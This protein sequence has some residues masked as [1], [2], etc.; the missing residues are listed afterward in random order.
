MSP[1]NNCRHLQKESLVSYKFTYKKNSNFLEN[2]SSNAYKKLVIKMHPIILDMLEKVEYNY[3]L[4]NKATYNFLAS[5]KLKLLY[6]HFC[7]LTLP[8]SNFVAIYLSDLLLLWP[9]SSQPK[10]LQRRKKEMKELLK[11]FVSLESKIDDL[12]VKTIV[13]DSEIIGV[14]VRKRKLSLV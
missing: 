3:A 14:A 4:L 1:Y 6:Y 10:T 9:R 12:D 8:G 11:T 5:D 13:D 7:L 2:S